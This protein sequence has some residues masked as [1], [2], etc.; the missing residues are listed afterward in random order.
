V[1]WREDKRTGEA[2]YDIDDDRIDSTTPSLFEEMNVP[3][4]VQVFGR[5]LRDKVRL[6]RC[7]GH[8]PG[9]LLF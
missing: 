7:G 4:K 1:A 6:L 2:D 8:A 5:K 3:R 9:V